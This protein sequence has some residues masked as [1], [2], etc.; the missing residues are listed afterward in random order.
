M[1]T[2]IKII[3]N[4]DIGQTEILQHLIWEIDEVS[5][6]LSNLSFTGREIYY[7]PV[8]TKLRAGSVV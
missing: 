3:C 6:Y 8:Y 4:D 1:E 7:A 5:P 2:G